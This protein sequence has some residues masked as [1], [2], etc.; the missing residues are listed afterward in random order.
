MIPKRVAQKGTLVLIPKK[1]YESLLRLRHER[2]AERELERE[3][4]VSLEE[5]R[6]GKVIGP[7]DN[8]EDLMKSLRGPKSRRAQEQTSF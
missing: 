1:E 6:Q 7:F 3:L 4:A 5:V 2:S 8:V